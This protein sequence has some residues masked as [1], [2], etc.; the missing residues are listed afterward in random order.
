M[1]SISDIVNALLPFKEKIA[2]Q[3]V[4]GWIDINAPVLNLPVI[5]QIVEFLV[6]QFIDLIVQRRREITRHK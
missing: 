2:V 6:Q 1:G 5:N 4:M 3:I